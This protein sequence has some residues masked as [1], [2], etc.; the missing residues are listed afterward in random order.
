MSTT[1]CLYAPQKLFKCLLS[2]VLDYK[3]SIN[4]KSPPQQFNMLCYHLTSL[5][6]VVSHNS[7]KTLKSTFRKSGFYSAF[8]LKQLFIKSQVTLNSQPTDGPLNENQRANCYLSN[9]PP[10][11]WMEFDYTTLPTIFYIWSSSCE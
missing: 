1:C 4:N 8:R 7:H 9:V 5:I 3:F 2:R 10:L 11:H 6:S